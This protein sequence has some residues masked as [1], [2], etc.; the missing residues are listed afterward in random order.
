LIDNPTE[1]QFVR[2]HIIDGCVEA[3]RVDVNDPK[4]LLMGKFQV[5]QA[6]FQA[7]AILDLQL[8]NIW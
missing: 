5:L 4:L 8:G 1:K 7:R 2:I 6:I 3:L